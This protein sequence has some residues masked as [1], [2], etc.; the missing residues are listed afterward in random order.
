[1]AVRNYLVE[2]VSG[3]GK[4]SVCAELMRRGYSTVN[5]DKELAYQGDPETGI[6]VEGF[7]HQTHIWDV[8]KALKL[9][10]DKNNKVLF[11]CGGSR[12]SHKF[13]NEFDR[14]FVLDVDNETI[15]ERLATRAEVSWGNNWGKSKEQLELVLKLNETK[16]DIPRDGIL[17]DATKPL[18]EVVKAILRHI[19]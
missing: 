3:S 5:G 18:E 19:Q 16:E 10:N 17:I 13:I 7:A 12:N 11:F 9:I 8:E 6:P 4:S 14:V 15:K 1:M 2:G